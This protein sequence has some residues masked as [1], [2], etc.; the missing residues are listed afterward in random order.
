MAEVIGTLLEGAC[1]RMPWYTDL[2]VIFDVLG[3]GERDFDWLVTDLKCNRLPPELRPQS[4]AWFF[5]GDA[6]SDLVRHEADP[7]QFEWAVLTGFHR[8]TVIDVEHLRV[9]PYADG[10]P[11]FWRGQPRIQH[12]DACVEIVCWDSS[13][14][15]LITTQ[16]ELTARFRAGFP[17]AVDLAAFNSR[18]R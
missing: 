2:Q 16:S 15:L 4:D 14:V 8:G 11:D 1:L 9:V 5:R 13:A 6:L 3:G 18:Q 7:V 17:E 10:N 12:P